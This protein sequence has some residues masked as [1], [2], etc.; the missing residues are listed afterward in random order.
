MEARAAIDKHVSTNDRSEVEAL[1]A[2]DLRSTDSLEREMRT[3]ARG[4]S[5]VLNRKTCTADRTPGG[6]PGRGGMGGSYL[7]SVSMEKSLASG[8]ETLAAWGGQPRTTAGLSTE[9]QILASSRIRTSP[10]VRRGHSEDGI[11]NLVMDSTSREKLSTC[12]RPALTNGGK[13]SSFESMR[14]CRLSAPESGGAPRF[15]ATNILVTAEA[16][17]SFWIRHSQDARLD[18]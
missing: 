7:A 9:R 2:F 10:T 15:E 11:R 16:R 8:R 12:I 3:S 13:S 1:M 18:H 17:R 5:N 14:R 4:R 6:S